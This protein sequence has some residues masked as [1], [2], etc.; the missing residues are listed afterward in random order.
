MEPQPMLLAL[1]VH[2][3]AEHCEA[4]GRRHVAT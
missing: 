3:T 2:I 4:Q 1:L